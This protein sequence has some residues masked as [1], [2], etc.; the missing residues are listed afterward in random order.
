[1]RQKYTAFIR[2]I[3]HRGKAP[4]ILALL[5]CDA[6]GPQA[7]TTVVTNLPPVH[8]DREVSQDAAVTGCGA[9]TRLVDVELAFTATPSNNVQIAFGPDLDGDGRLSFGEARMTVGW[10]CGRWFIAPGDQAR[11][12]TYAPEGASTGSLH[13][14]LR[15]SMRLNEAGIPLSLPFTDGG[16]PFTFDGLADVPDWVR[17]REWGA[18]RLTARG[19]D[20]RDE[21]ALV[22]MRLD[23]NVIIL[24]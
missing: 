17:P 13:R 22:K 5:L 20:P 12:F 23:G 3:V 14:T 16:A 4:L 19:R 15:M 7:A 6:I 21:N 11:H 1:M 9:R 10:D 8:A 18:L 24:R 2:S